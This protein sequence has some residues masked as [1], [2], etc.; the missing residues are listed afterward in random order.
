MAISAGL[1]GVFPSGV[2]S[3]TRILCGPAAGALPTFRDKFGLVSLK[4]R[5]TRRGRLE[6]AP[7]GLY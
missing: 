5:S 7:A 4:V 3:G 2:G 1:A 6:A